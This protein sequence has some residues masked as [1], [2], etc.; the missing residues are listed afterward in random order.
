MPSLEDNVFSFTKVR[1]VDFSVDLPYRVFF[2]MVL[3]FFFI[4]GFGVCFMYVRLMCYVCIV[5]CVGRSHFIFS[6]CGLG[7][8]RGLW[9]YLGSMGFI[10]GSWAS[11]GFSVF[12]C[13]YIKFLSV[14]FPC[15]SSVWSFLSVVDGFGA[16]GRDFGL[17]NGRSVAFFAGSDGTTTKSPCQYT[18]L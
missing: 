1:Y 4:S 17:R 13:I 3:S 11:W 14:H 6:A 16:L 9:V 18:Y 5:W 10:L 12:L 7:L 15:V 2:G 8:F